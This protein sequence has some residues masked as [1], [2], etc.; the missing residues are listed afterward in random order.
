MS[1]LSLALPATMEGDAWYEQAKEKKPLPYDVLTRD[2]VSPFIIML[3]KIVFCSEKWE[4]GIENMKW[5]AHDC[6]V[7]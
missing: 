2:R 4:W 6:I 1:T 3:W 7:Q 5:V